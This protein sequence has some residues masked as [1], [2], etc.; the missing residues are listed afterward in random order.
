MKYILLR[1]HHVVYRAEVEAED[2]FKAMGK[3]SEAE[4]A[5]ESDTIV[6]TSAN[7]GKETVLV[8]LPEQEETEGS[9]EAEDRITVRG[10]K[11]L[12]RTPFDE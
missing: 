6:V 8:K 3:S 11:V 2:A 7:R 9:V 1:T 4:W 12:K 10:M 5:E